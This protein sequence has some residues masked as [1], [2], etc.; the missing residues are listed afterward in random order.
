M[1][2][3]QYEKTLGMKGYCEIIGT[4]NLDVMIVNSDSAASICVF[5]VN[6]YHRLDFSVGFEHNAIRNILLLD[7]RLSYITALRG[8]FYI[9]GF[10]NLR[11]TL[12]VTFHSTMSADDKG[13]LSTD[14]MT[15]ERQALH[16]G[17]KY[18][19]LHGLTCLR[20]I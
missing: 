20:I 11:E 12:S 14:S 19:V 10:D 2:A 8:S 15:D 7:D 13:T 9:C 6:D 17:E 4:S 18:Q 5:N 1:R 3:E 16:N